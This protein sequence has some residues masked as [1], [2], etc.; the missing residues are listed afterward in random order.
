MDN[1]HHHDDLVLQIGERMRE[2]G[3]PGLPQN[4][5]LFYQAYAG[6]SEKL[7]AKLS[8][9]GRRPAQDVLDNLFQEHGAQA[10]YGKLVEGAHTRMVA[11]IGDIMA[12]LARE[13][14]S[15]ERY[16]QL[17]DSTAVGIEGKDVGQQALQKIASILAKATST[18]VRQSHA[19]AQSMT[20]RSAELHDIKQE[21]AAYKNLA[22]TD[23]LTQLHNRRAFSRSLDGVFQESRLRM[24]STLVMLD[25]D[26][27][28]DINDRYGHLVG[29]KVLQ[30]L[31]D[32]LRGKCG[33]HVSI[34]RVGGEEFA[35]LI[36][37]E[38]E[39][40][41]LKFVE[42]IRKAAELQPFGDVASGLSVTL[43]AGICKATDAASPD[44]LFDKAD[45][46]LYV[47][48]A[49]GRNRITVYPPPALSE[50][51]YQRKNWM[52]YRED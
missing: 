48:K 18:T 8:A 22:D 41:T 1:L 27:F 51:T 39:A 5:A 9:L 14:D 25:I 4:Y 10:E 29:D 37:G 43:S 15:L 24:L 23:F 17:L 33:P 7:R 16:I 46:A 49:E 26:R 52:L 31:A 11:A 20:A 47:S 50:R 30:M 34:F 38:S 3:V 42:G 40:S 13:Q 21:L 2:A 36:E 32:L 6:G 19:S 45:S 35:L 44:D 28:K 12:L